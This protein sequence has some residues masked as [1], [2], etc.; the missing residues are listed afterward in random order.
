MVGPNTISSTSVAPHP[1]TAEHHSALHSV[2]AITAAAVIH[3]KRKSTTTS[4]S[5]SVPTLNIHSE[6]LDVELIKYL[7]RVYFH[8]KV[9]RNELLDTTGKM[10]RQSND[11]TAT[12]PSTQRDHHHQESGECTPKRA[13]STLLR[14]TYFDDFDLFRTT[15]TTDHN[16][17]AA[18][19]QQLL[20]REPPQQ[21]TTT[22]R[23]AERAQNVS[24]ISYNKSSSAND[25]DAYPLPQRPPNKTTH[26]LDKPYHRNNE[27]HTAQQPQ[28]HHPTAQ[29]VLSEAAAAVVIPSG[30]YGVSTVCRSHVSTTNNSSSTELFESSRSHVELEGEEG[31]AEELELE[32][33]FKTPRSHDSSTASFGLVSCTSKVEDD[34]V[35]PENLQC[36]TDGGGGGGSA[37][38]RNSEPV[39]G[40]SSA[41]VSCSSSAVVSSTTLRSTSSFEQPL[42]D[43]Q[44]ALS[45]GAGAAVVTSECNT[46]ITLSAG[47]AG[48]GPLDKHK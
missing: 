19:G 39:L 21:Q 30:G 9:L 34:T 48:V 25:L 44:S 5:S 20:S 46:S 24:K 2:A 43:Y 26:S 33:G 1:L 47:G 17:A 16:K 22:I 6:H 18:A 42:S 27:Q 8:K 35:V 10:K 11:T 3:P 13:A 29:R 28:H 36:D 40:E 32:G 37:V 23:G 7:Y 4:S 12:N 31:E 15:G 38:L 14:V 41:D 45:P